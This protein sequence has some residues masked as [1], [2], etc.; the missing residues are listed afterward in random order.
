MID[1]ASYEHHVMLINV[2]TAHTDDM[3]MSVTCCLLQ[4]WLTAYH[5]LQAASTLTNMKQWL[6]DIAPG[7][8][9]SEDFTAKWHNSVMLFLHVFRAKYPTQCPLAANITQILI[10]CVFNI[11]LNYQNFVHFQWF[12]NAKDAS[13]SCAFDCMGNNIRCVVTAL[14]TMLCV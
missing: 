8:T 10:W 11:T 7:C 4:A 9:L 1:T 14:M 6:H 13:C 3:L 2:E 5:M 12:L